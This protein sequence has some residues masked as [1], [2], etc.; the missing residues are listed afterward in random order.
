MS[1]LQVFRHRPGKPGGDSIGVTILDDTPAP[2]FAAPGEKYL[3]KG[4]IGGYY[5]SNGEGYS[6]NLAASAAIDSLSLAY[7]GTQAK[8]QNYRT[9]GT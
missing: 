3:L 9:G 2:E 6:T 7:S 4:E 5:Q 8:S 1:S